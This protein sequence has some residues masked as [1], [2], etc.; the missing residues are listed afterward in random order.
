MLKSLLAGYLATPASDIRFRY[1]AAGKPEI[2]AEQ[3]AVGLQFNVSHSANIALLA[4]VVGR[5]IGVDIEQLQENIKSQ[6]LTDRLFSAGEQEQ[7][8]AL[9]HSLR[10]EG[11]FACWTR[12][13][14]FIKATGAGLSTPLV[15]FSVT[16]HPHIG[17]RLEL[18]EAGPEIARRWFLA[19]LAAPEGFRAALAVQGSPIAIRC[20][21]QAEITS[22]LHPLSETPNLVSVES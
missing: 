22:Y 3:N 10:T 18:P 9:P 20:L 14:A 16:V 1:G 7:F 19:D 17:V 13:E 6:A 21:E 15:D 11:F 5:Q 2:Q 4:F 8:L 12:K